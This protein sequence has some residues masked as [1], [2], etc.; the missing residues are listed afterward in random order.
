MGPP[1]TIMEELPVSEL[2]GNLMY[3]NTY[4][5]MQQLILL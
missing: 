4:H 5:I 2:T 1:V 3:A